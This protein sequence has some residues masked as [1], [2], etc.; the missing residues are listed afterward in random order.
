M[1]AEEIG[2]EIRVAEMRLDEAAEPLHRDGGRRLPAGLA[3]RGAWPQTGGDQPFGRAGRGNP[4]AVRQV[5]CFRVERAH[6][7]E[8]QRVQRRAVRQDK[9]MQ[10][11]DV[12]DQWLQGA[13]G[14]TT[15]RLV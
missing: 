15:D 8:K 5:R 1:L 2:P 11:I 6:V 3:A 13:R 14:T 10:P 9:A 12:G 4:L 7:G